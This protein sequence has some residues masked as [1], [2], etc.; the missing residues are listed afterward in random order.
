MEILP[1]IYQDIKLENIKF[2]NFAN[3]LKKLTREDTNP[4]YKGL[5]SI[6]SV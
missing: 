6:N 3:V 4:L 1:E 2:L 5:T